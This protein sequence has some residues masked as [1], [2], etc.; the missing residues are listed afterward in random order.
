MDEL[1]PLG[2]GVLLGVAFACRLR[3]LAPPWRKA[4]LLVLVGVAS[5]LASGEADV[6]WGFALGDIGEVGLMAWIASACLRRLY[7]VARGIRVRRGP[8]CRQLGR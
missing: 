2:L 8:A 5:T 7:P 6:S 4:M 1:L 3:L